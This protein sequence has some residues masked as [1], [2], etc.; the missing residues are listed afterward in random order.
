VLRTPKQHTNG[1]WSDGERVCSVETV[2]MD[3]LS[4]E[5][6]D[7]FHVEG[8]LWSTLF[9][10]LYEEALFQPLHGMLPSPHLRAPLD[11]GTPEFRNRR[12]SAIAAVELDILN[13]FAGRRLST[14]WAKRHGQDIA[15]VRWGL[16]TRADL[17]RIVDGL[18]VKA[19][20]SIM[21]I[22]TLDWWN[23]QRGWPDLVV[24]PKERIPLRLV[25]V[26]GPSDSLRDAQRWWLAELKRMGISNEV[27]SVVPIAG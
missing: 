27:W 21:K 16:L 5:G 10:L 13:G 15:G 7:A 1:R 24:L 19:L 23:A 6:F 25:E 8:A 22:F 17:V 20:A 2:V 12:E 11:L 14:A 4:T 9:G 18:P 3:A 26:K